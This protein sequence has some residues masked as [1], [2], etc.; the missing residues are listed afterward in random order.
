VAGSAGCKEHRRAR[1]ERR[2]SSVA[3]EAELLWLIRVASGSG[4]ARRTAEAQRPLYHGLQRRCV[5]SSRTRITGEAAMAEARWRRHGSGW[6]RRGRTVAGAGAGLARARGPRRRRHCS[7]M[8]LFFFF[9]FFSHTSLSLCFSLSLLS[10]AFP[11]NPH[12]SHSPVSLFTFYFCF[13]SLREAPV[14]EALHS[15]FIGK[16]ISLFCP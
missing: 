16:K 5:G 7:R 13:F 8:T 1:S 9:F 2:A 12:T 14:S 10:F 6:R 15:L 4:G 3:A 11:P